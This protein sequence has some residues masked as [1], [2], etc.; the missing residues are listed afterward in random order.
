MKINCVKEKNWNIEFTYSPLFEMLCSLHVLF[1]PDHHL[2]RVSWAEEMK[3][4]LPDKLYE[5]LMEYEEKT[6]EWCAVMDFCNIYEECNDFNIMASMNFLEDLDMKA[7][8]SIF[9]K[10]NDYRQDTFN[11][12]SRKQ[13][14]RSM[15]EYYLNYF[16]KELRFIEPLLIRSLKRN[17]EMC[18]KKGI[19]YYINEL[20]SRIEVT[21]K[22]FIFHKYKLFIVCFDTLKTVII[23]ISSFINP[24]LLMDFDD[25]MVQF[26]AFAHLQGEVVNVP[27]DLIKL[28]K[29]LSDKTRLKIVRKLYG[30]KHS[31]QSLAKELKL[32]EACISKHLKI[33][34]E[35]EILHKERNGNYIYYYLD[36]FF[37]DRIPLS[38]Y[39]YLD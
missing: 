3:N 31:T 16:E 29:A 13:M 8:N 38:I 25:H 22:A 7:F 6:Y 35:A 14:L 11:D 21:D 12:I 20:H 33:L 19:L 27:M 23:R 39:E 32:T 36:T 37:I 15:K 30:T 24:H 9:S 34:Y 10:Y 1:K 26:T 2:E 4:Q 18:L 17:A 5:D 28:M